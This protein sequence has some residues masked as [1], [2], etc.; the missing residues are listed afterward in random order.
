VT[1][2]VTKLQKGAHVL[3]TSGPAKTVSVSLKMG[4]AMECLNAVMELMSTCAH[5]PDRKM[6]STDVVKSGLVFHW[7]TYAME[8]VTAYNATMRLKRIPATAISLL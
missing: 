8:P 2:E 7:T 3:Q 6:N 5:A 1:T 4:G